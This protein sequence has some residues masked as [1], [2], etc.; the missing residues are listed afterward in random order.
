M[1]VRPERLIPIVA[2]V[3]TLGTA[4]SAQTEKLLFLGTQIK[5]DAGTYLV[6]KDVNVRAKPLTGS[7]RVGGFKRGD[8]I[9]VVG[10]APGAW[11]AVRK[12]G[13]DFGFVYEPILLPLIDGTLDKELTGRIKAKGSPACDYRVRFEGKS[14]AEGQLFKFADYE[15]A[16]KCTVGKSKIEF[17]TPMFM[18]EAP[19]QA[20]KKGIYQITIDHLE[21]EDN[22]E[23]VIS[24]T[25]YFKRKKKQVNFDSVSSKKYRKQPA[26]KEMQ[27]DDVA[28]ALV[29]AV[30]LSYGA[31]NKAVW[32]DLSKTLGQ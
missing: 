20:S 16:W 11:V 6:T 13:K 31:W 1:A 14:V 4:A 18:T 22:L 29:V 26:V 24:T 8:R 7:K 2:I 17:L 9:K 3:A 32:R 27:A 10:R 21:L 15:V 23:E 5:A 12:G 30:R 28:Q 19:Y 25:V